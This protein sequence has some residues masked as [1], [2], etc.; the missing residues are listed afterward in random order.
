MRR[1]FVAFC[2]ALIL[3][4][5]LLPIYWLVN[6]SFQPRTDFYALPVFLLPRH[7]TL[8]NYLAALGLLKPNA[9]GFGGD[10]GLFLVPGFLAAMKNS[11]LVAT[12]VM[13]LTIALSLPASYAF[14]R[15]S[16][17]ARSGIFA[18]ILF[19]RSIPPIS[20][21]V[22]YYRFYKD[23]GLL[24]TLPGIVLVDLTLT[25]PLT[26]WV[27]SGF[28]SSLPVELD[29]QARIDGCSRVQMLRRVLIPIAAPGLAAV[30]ILA[31]LDSWNEFIYALLLGDVR[32]LAL[33]S[34]EVSS[35]MFGLGGSSPGLFVAFVVISLVP[36]VIAAIV[37]VPY[38]TRLRIADPLTFRT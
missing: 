7:P 11:L 8:V 32:G 23:T 20:T 16:F 22:P 3:V 18:L 38:M 24:G 12:T 28:I 9:Q 19:A 27:L 15:F 33:I 5:T 26:T 30:S 1:I 2:A 10:A 29:R 6:L 4:W 14:A 31:W 25:I 36:S 13:F 34:P 21:A 35:Q 17:R 37:L